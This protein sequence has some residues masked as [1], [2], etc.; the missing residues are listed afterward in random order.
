MFKHLKVDKFILAEKTQGISGGLEQQSQ[1]RFSLSWLKF[2]IKIVQ[3]A[4]K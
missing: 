3:F 2:H 1:P 4:L